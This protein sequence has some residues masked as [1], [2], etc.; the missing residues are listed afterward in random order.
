MIGLSD[1]E[2]INKGFLISRDD[3]SLD[4]IENIIR[5]GISCR[6]YY[7]SYYENQWN[8]IYLENMRNMMMELLE[9]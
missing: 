1:N 7:S 3:K 9:R 6:D 2:I 5:N 4:I 8:S